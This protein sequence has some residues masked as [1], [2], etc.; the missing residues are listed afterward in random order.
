M[1]RLLVAL[2]FAALCAGALL[3]PTLAQPKDEGEYVNKGNR[4]DSAR[5]TLA[6]YKLPN[7]D[8]KWY[9]AGP[10]D[11]VNKAGFDTAY[12]PEKKVDLKATYEGKDGA[13]VTWK[14]FKDFK[15]G[16]IVD[17]H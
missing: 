6:T 16:Q 17:F 3:V 10:F 11:N 14:E 8:G 7:L 9:Y 2:A 15:T 12:P 5:A 1:T 4:P 13:K